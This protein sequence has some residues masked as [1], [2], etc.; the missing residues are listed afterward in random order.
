MELSLLVTLAITCLAFT[1]IWLINVITEDAGVIDYFWGP[2]FAVIG[3]VH[4]YFHPLIGPLHAIFLAAVI[5]WSLR[6]AIHLVRRHHSTPHEDGRYRVMRQQGGPSWWWASLFKVFLLQGVLLWMIAAPVHAVFLSSNGFVPLT[7]MFV[8][9]M[10]VFVLGLAIEWI[11]DVQLARGKAAQNSGAE[12][13]MVTTGL[14]GISRHPNYVGEMVLWWGLAIAAFALTGAWWVFAGPALLCAV[15]IGVSL[16]LTEQHMVR[17]R[18][19]Y[20]AYMERVPALVGFGGRRS[21]RRK[22][23]A[24]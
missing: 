24:E 22:Q 23:P 3:I 13:E 9:G 18:P 21:A 14:W 7:A 16:P 1:G 4:L 17:T 15:V 6:L 20:G 10:A 11:S 2:G 19:A 12:S 5:F 8:G